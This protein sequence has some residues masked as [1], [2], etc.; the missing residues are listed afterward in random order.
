MHD[1]QFAI[2]SCENFVDYCRAAGVRNVVEVTVGSHSASVR[3]ALVKAGITCRRW[4]IVRR[5]GIEDILRQTFD[6]FYSIIE[7]SGRKWL[8]DV[9]YFNDNFA[10]QLHRRIIE[11]PLARIVDGVGPFGI[12]QVGH[13]AETRDGRLHRIDIVIRARDR[14]HCTRILVPLRLPLSATE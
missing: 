10:T 7:K 8:P 12:M 2:H 5:G 14:H 4:P 11:A 6:A 9:L 1:G 3:D 13:H